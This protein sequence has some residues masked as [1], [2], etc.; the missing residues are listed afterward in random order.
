M[1]HLVIRDAELSDVDTIVDIV[2]R[3][4]RG[5]EGEAGWTTESQFL[6][7]QRTDRDEVRAEVNDPNGKLLVATDQR[8]TLVG[9]IKVDRVAD[10]VHFGLFAVDPRVQGTGAGNALL[11]AVDDLARAWGCSWVGMEVLNLRLDIKAWYERKGFRPTGE[12]IAFPYGDDRFGLPR[13]DDLQ[14]DGYR[15]SL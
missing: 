12:V 4:Y 15:K 9:C 5:G 11:K 3:A 2:A 10:G 6:G 8:G 1:E 7:G 14:F 13:R